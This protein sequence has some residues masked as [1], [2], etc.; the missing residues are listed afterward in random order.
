MLQ[1]LIKYFCGERADIRAQ[2]PRL[3]NVYGMPDG[4]DEH[5]GLVVVIIKNSHDIASQRHPILPDII[6]TSNEW[7]DERSASLG[8]HQRLRSRENER[9]I[10]TDALAAQHFR[11]L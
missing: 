11:G 3:D 6:E 4:R 10:H 1:H 7:T 5:L 2:E 9:D 8:C